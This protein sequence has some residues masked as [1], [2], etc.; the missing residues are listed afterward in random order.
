[1]KLISRAAAIT[2]A[3]LAMFQ[4]SACRTSAAS[5]T[6]CTAA[7]AL[8]CWWRDDAQYCGGGENQYDDR[9]GS[10]WFSHA[11]IQPDYHY[12]SIAPQELADGQPHEMLSPVRVSIEPASDCESRTKRHLRLLNADRQPFTVLLISGRAHWHA[13]ELRLVVDCI[14]E[15]Q[16][17]GVSEE[18]WRNLRAF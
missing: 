12:W 1:M 4:A 13:T 15:S 11:L 2:M 9:T 5:K 17:L 16:L 3:A 18:A 6:S 8:S 14:C 10:F 7:A